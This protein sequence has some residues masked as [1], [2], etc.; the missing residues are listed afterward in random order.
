MSRRVQNLGILT[1][2]T[3]VVLALLSTAFLGTAHAADPE[4]PTGAISGTIS[5]SR[6]VALHAPRELRVAV[7]DSQGA[8]VGLF[9]EVA[10]DGTYTVTGLATGSYR[11]HIQDWQ[12]SYLY[13]YFGGSDSLD[14]ATPVA[15]TDGQTTNGIDVALALSVVLAGTFV[16]PGGEQIDDSSWIQVSAY[17]ETGAE[18]G[19]ART[20]D[21]SSFELGKIPTGRYRLA[22]YDSL[23]GYRTEYFDN[24]DS[25]VGSQ[26]VDVVRGEIRDLGAIELSRANGTCE[27]DSPTGKPTVTSLG[28]QLTATWQAGWTP[29][30]PD[31]TGYVVSSLPAGAGCATTGVPTCV[32][33]GVTA[34]V[35]YRFFVSATNAG[36]TSLPSAPSAIVRGPAPVVVTPSRD[37]VGKKQKV[38]KRPARVG[39]G[40]SKSLPKRSTAGVKVNWKSLTPRKCVV[41]NG[42]VYG[43][44]VGKCRLKAVAKAKGSWLR[45]EAVTALR[46]R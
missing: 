17:D 23:C 8:Q 13:Q 37:F 27:P 24:S 35:D 5:D 10:V 1:A 36:G 32:L 22:F 18:V 46:V 33:T 43:K 9:G 4:E 44:S 15:V 11:V 29:G 41:R 3:A 14:Q 19:G 7:F 42:K 39:S 6:G 31:V 20:E 16:G 38:T 40:R 26:F 34:G 45:Y 30:T 12:D 21:D 25:F 2:V 28:G